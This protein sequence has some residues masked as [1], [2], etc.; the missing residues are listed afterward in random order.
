MQPVAKASKPILL[1]AIV[2]IIGIA[3]G[4]V[5]PVQLFAWLYPITSYLYSYLY[6][7]LLMYVSNN[8]FF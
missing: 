4:Y 7:D 6:V 8:T 3:V 1:W 5:M 2:G